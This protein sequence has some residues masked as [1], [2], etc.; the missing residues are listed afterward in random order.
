MS[1]TNTRTR[2]RT[3]NVGKIFITVN[4]IAVTFLL[5]KILLKSDLTVHA[6]LSSGGRKFLSRVGW[7]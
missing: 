7:S 6:D 2:Y 3:H 1:F 5:D 4:S